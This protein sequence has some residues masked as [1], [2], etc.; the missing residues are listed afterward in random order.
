MKSLK[1]F[2]FLVA[3][4]AVSLAAWADVSV[5]GYTRK[6][7]TYVAPHY[8]SSPNG[9]KNDNW[10]TRG[11]V[12][13]YT[14]EAGTKAPDPGYAQQPPAPP[15]T[16]AQPQPPVVAHAPVT[17]DPQKVGTADAWNMM[18]PSLEADDVKALLG[19]PE[20]IE[21][22][23]WKYPNKGRVAFGSNGRVGVWIPPAF[24]TPSE[25]KILK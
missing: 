9:T 2:L 10:S 3:S 14:G 13:P 1:F 6:D 4:F 24:P 23:I 16:P 12:N 25:A 20:T 21:N 18:G 15:T 17:I 19:P 7:G 11:N 22:G 5:K 8:R